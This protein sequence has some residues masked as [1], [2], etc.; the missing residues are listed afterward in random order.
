MLNDIKSDKILIILLFMFAETPLKPKFIKKYTD[1]F[2]V[3]KWIILF[4]ITIK[5]A[6][7]HYY[8][9]VFLIMYLTLYLV[10]RC[11]VLYKIK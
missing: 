5:R 11:L 1:D 3:F 9:L 10:D 8:F 4:L 2:P 6:D 7:G